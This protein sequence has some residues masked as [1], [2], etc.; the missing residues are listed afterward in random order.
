MKRV[1]HHAVQKLNEYAMRDGF[2]YA[3][4]FSESGYGR[5]LTNLNNALLSGE[6][7]LHEAYKAVDQ[8]VPGEYRKD[9]PTSE[10]IQ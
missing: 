6:M 2:F 3:R 5:F 9:K 1:S 10:A 8:F 4:A 7:T